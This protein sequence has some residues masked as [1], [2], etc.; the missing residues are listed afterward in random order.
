[1]DEY[2]MLEILQLYIKDEMSKNDSS[3]D[4][5]HVKRVYNNAILINEEEKCNPFIIK[6]IALLHDIYDHKYSNGSIKT[7]LTKLLIKLDLYR[8]LNQQIFK[9]Y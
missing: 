4:W 1:M 5:W 8:F 3:H 9:I 7:N 6:V 2:R